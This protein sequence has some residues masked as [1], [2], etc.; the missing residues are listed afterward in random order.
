MIA[1]LIVFVTYG[2]CLALVFFLNEHVS[3]RHGEYFF[4]K[5]SMIKHLYPLRSFLDQLENFL[6][7][8][9]YNPCR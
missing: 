5:K 9:I 3:T 6:Y 4:Q 7:Q 8:A 1:F 2:A